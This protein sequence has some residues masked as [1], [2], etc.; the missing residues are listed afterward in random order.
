[1]ISADIYV[2]T[3]ASLLA[4]VRPFMDDASV[5]EIMINGPSRIYVERKGKLEL[6]DARFA[7][8]AALL[9]ALRNIA[10]YA[11]T[12]VDEKHPILEARLP[13]GSRVEAV[14]SPVAEGGPAV[15]IRRFSRTS[16]DLRRLVALGALGA[17]AAE[18][19]NAFTVAKCNI[20]IGG[21]TGS[22]KTSLLNVLAGCA[23]VDERV[24]VLEDTR[25]I[26][27]EREHVLYLEAQKAGQ[28][29]EPA[30]TIRDLFRAALRMRPD[31][32]I[33]GE[34]RGAEA[35]DMVQAMVSGHGGC[36][37][38]LHASYPRDTLTRLETMCMMSDVS[39]P[40][41]AI[42]SQVGSGIQVI[43]Q[44]SRLRD[45]SRKIT[46][47]TEVA[48]FDV[49]RNQYQTHDLFERVYRGLDSDGC[50]LSELVA[51]GHV[52]G[53]AGQLAEH[54][55]SLPSALRFGQAATGGADR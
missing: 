44:V 31:R 37:A 42:R 14:L 25:E 2:Q 1:M 26:D 29:G 27:V 55:V 17:D 41:A 35:L 51:T 23:P 13:D 5:S 45:G 21:G 43:V 12:Y 33:V 46:H 34:I 10:Q 16:L 22:G 8:G 11:G 28:N 24:L 39:M 4:P 7:S 48:G 38:T 40:L 15:S 30:V 19:L 54:G 20:V 36:L 47:I 18:A 3:L 52:P 53:F 49:E 32:I 9:A 50:V 6:T